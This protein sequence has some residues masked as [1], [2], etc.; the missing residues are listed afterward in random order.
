MEFMT[1]ITARSRAWQPTA[2]TGAVFIGALVLV[3]LM[4][5]VCPAIAPAPASCRPDARESAALAGGTLIVIVAAAGTGLT[6]VVPLR[7]RYGTITAAM[8]AVGLAGVVAIIMAVVASGFI[9][10]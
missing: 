1:S 3:A 7:W 2:A 9:L 4:P 8:I 5:E 6:Y 10:I